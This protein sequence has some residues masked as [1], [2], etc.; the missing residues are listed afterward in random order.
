[1]VN[2]D[3]TESKILNSKN[4]TEKPLVNPGSQG[5]EAFSASIVLNSGKAFVPVQENGALYF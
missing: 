2:K 1:M 5:G 4:A 3:H